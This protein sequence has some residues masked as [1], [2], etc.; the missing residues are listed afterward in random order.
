MTF[1]SRTPAQRR[2]YNARW[3]A[4]HPEW[5]A[6][7]NAW[8][9]AYRKKHPETRTT[10][11]ILGPERYARKLEKASEYYFRKKIERLT[12]KTFYTANQRGDA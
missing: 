3:K 10:L 8:M 6:H 2:A 1:P 4:K 5:R 7:R 11:E 9:R 12:G